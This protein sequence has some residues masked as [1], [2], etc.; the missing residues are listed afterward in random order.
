VNSTSRTSPNSRSR[1]E[2]VQLVRNRERRRERRPAAGA[3]SRNH[4]R[5]EHRTVS[6]TSGCA[7]PVEGS[8]ENA[9]P[10]PDDRPRF[11]NTIACTVTAVPCR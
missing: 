9:T 2:D 5:P 4:P 11:P 7:D 1:P 10:A 3:A 8:R 6:I